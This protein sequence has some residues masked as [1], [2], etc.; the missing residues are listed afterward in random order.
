[1]PCRRSSC[2]NYNPHA[3][4][5]CE[6]CDEFE[7]QKRREE[8]GIFCTHCQ[9]T[10]LAGEFDRHRFRVYYKIHEFPRGKRVRL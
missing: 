7:T 8:F 3:E 6:P 9:K 2:P 10:M 4:E 5:L 1:M